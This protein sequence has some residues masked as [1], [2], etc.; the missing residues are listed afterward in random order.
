M[1]FLKLAYTKREA[2]KASTSWPGCLLRG[3]SINILFYNGSKTG[4]VQEYV[5]SGLKHKPD[6]K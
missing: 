1:E 2:V 4:K 3:G 5:A 6:T